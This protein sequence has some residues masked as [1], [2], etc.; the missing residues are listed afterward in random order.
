MVLTCSE[1]HIVEDDI[2]YYDCLDCSK[3]NICSC[4]IKTLS[5]DGNSYYG[6]IECSDK[7]DININKR[8]SIRRKSFID[9]VKLSCAYRGILDDPSMIELNKVLDDYLNNGELLDKEIYIVDNNKIDG[10]PTK[11][12]YKIVINLYN[13]NCGRID[14]F[15]IRAI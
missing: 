7:E 13:Y 1:C 9:S 4:C 5:Q 12:K 15:S 10:Y 11:N 2:E 6:C 3:R 14:T 8:K